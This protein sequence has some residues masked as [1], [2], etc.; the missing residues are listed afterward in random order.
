MTGI[1]ELPAR[2]RKGRAAT[3]RRAGLV[4]AKAACCAL[5]T[6]AIWAGA[7]RGVWFM[8]FIIGA[9]IGLSAP[10][11]A[12]SAKMALAAA[13]LAGLTGWVL[14][15]L[16]LLLHGEPVG[17]TARVVAALAGLPPYAAV[18]VVATVLIAVLQAAVGTWLGWSVAALVFPG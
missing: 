2:A 15:L 13:C 16:W 7:T 3:G 11:A 10:K 12:V 1:K 9:L 14:P 18:V 5:G 8:P 4:A 17:A 6:V